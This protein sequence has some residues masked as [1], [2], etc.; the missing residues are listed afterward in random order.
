MNPLKALRGARL[1]AK[2]GDLIEKGDY[3]GAKE[4]IE[5]ARNLLGSNLNKP[6][7]F[8]LHLRAATIHHELGEE[9]SASSAIHLAIRGMMNYNRLSK[10]DR[11]YLLDYCDH[12]LADISRDVGL[13]RYRV[14]KSD[15][16]RV[17]KRYRQ[18]YPL[19]W[20]D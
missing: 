13:L 15:Y 14:H 18:E 19:A 12:F 5:E 6:G 2:S 1:F 3:V 20:I 4:A 11:D 7:M 8:E 9:N 10:M 16:P 17:S